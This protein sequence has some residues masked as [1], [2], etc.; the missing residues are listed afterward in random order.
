MDLDENSGRLEWSP[1]ELGQ[2]PV[3][4]RVSDGNEGEDSQAFTVQVIDRDTDLDTL[5]D[6]WERRY[7]GTLERD[8]FDDYDCDGILDRDEFDNGLDPTAPDRLPFQILSI[9]QDWQAGE[10]VHIQWESQAGETYTILLRDEPAGPYTVVDEVVVEDSV[11]QWT[12]DGLWSGGTHPGSQEERYYRITQG[13]YG[14]ANTVGMFRTT[15]PEG[16]NPVEP[17]LEPMGSAVEECLG[18]GFTGADNERDA[19][20]VWAWDGAIFEIAYLIDGVGLEHD[21]TWYTGNAPAT[22]TLDTDEDLWIQI[23][24]GHGETVVF[25]LGEVPCF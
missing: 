3:E 20:R 17:P 24:V 6:A 1:L 7:F 12:D 15:L 25:F 21:G 18:G 14:S 5:P 13:I 19:D 2:Y 22:M 16:M 9:S 23:R 4:I 10:D 8:G 11:S